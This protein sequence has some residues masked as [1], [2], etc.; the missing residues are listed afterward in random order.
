MY[1]VRDVVG[2]TVTQTFVASHEAGDVDAVLAVC[3]DTRGHAGALSL[4]I[5]NVAVP[6]HSLH[7]RGNL[8]AIRIS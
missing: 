7:V 3:L 4:D 8:R 5:V 2:C 1:H 6:H